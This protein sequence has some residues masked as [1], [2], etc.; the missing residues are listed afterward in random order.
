M[1]VIRHA[2][3]FSGHTLYHLVVIILLV[4]CFIVLLYILLNLCLHIILNQI[5]LTRGYTPFHKDPVIGVFLTDVIGEV[6]G[7]AYTHT[8]KHTYT[9]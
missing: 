9:T 8:C 5:G 7:T 3:L 4:I 1:Y 2:Y 6:G